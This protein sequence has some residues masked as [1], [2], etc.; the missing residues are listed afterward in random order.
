M[1]KVHRCADITLVYTALVALSLPLAAQ[2]Q[3]AGKA[4]ATVQ[5]ESNSNVFYLNRGAAPPG[6]DSHRGDTYVAYGAQFD[7]TYSWRRQE[8]YATAST[9]QSDYQRYSKLNH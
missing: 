7:A 3:F 2:A 9:T 8:I 5:V 1:L 6:N 4:S